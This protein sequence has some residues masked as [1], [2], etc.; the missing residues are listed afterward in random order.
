VSVLKACL[1]YM[2]LCISEIGVGLAGFGIAFLFLGILLFF[3]KGLLA[4]GNVSIVCNFRCQDACLLFCISH[5]LQSTCICVE[6]HEYHTVKIILYKAVVPV[7][8]SS[9]YN[10][11]C[12]ALWD[13]LVA[14]SGEKWLVFMFNIIISP[15][16]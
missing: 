14:I 12:V 11:V 3:D 8:S 4:I 2:S 9:R 1:Y 6:K 13:H 7:C 5:V 10:Y 15:V 16:W